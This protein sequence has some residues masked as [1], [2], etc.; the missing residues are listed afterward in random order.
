MRSQRW[1]I[2]YTGT[3][4]QP[5]CAHRNTERGT[6]YLSGR[7]SRKQQFD[8]KYSFI[9]APSGTIYPY[10]N[11]KNWQSYKMMRVNIDL[12]MY[13]CFISVSGWC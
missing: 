8:T 11:V 1:V 6:A 12:A 10:S 4:K 9:T 2:P 5:L 3:E 7:D 13:S